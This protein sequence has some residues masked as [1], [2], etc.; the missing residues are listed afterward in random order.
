MLFATDGIIT[1]SCETG[2][3]DRLVNI[4]TPER[5]R[6]G[7]LVK[8]SKLASLSQVF[9]Y[10]NFEIYE[11][12][13]MYWLRGGSVTRSFYSLTDDLERMAL[14]SYLCDVANE[15]TD[16]NEDASQ[17]MSLLLNS[18]YALSQ[19][20]KKPS[21]IKAVF[22]LRTSFFSGYCPEV[23]GCVYCKK[24][25]AESVYLDVSGGRLICSD[26]LQKRSKKRIVFSS[27]FDYSEE[28]TLL[29]QLTPSSLAALRYIL[30]SP[31]SR[32]FAFELKD[33][34]ELKDLCSLA[35]AYL[36]EHVERGFDTLD[37][38]KSVSRNN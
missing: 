21:L 22:E 25:Y 20:L 26:C 18:L 33:E 35:E 5:G 14:A 32:I 10:G 38:Y 24:Q 15:M 28:K 31:P 12:N 17:M 27:E 4:I 3:G 30:S 29:C 23:S 34:R 16:E 2:K 9:S 6:L 8:G 36:L 1:R 19:E 7:V 11:K 37:F 13:S